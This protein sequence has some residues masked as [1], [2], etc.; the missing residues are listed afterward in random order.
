MALGPLPG[1]ALEL[2]ERLRH[3]GISP[4]LPDQ[5]IVNE[6]LPGQGIASHIDCEPCF[7]G[8]ICSLSLGSSCAMVM[9]QACDGRQEQI[10]LVPGSLLVSPTQPAMPGAT[11][12]RH[13]SKKAS[14]ARLSGVAGAFRSLSAPS[15][16]KKADLKRVLLQSGGFWRQMDQASVL[17]V[18]LGRIPS[19]FT[20]GATSPARPIPDW[21]KV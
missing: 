13:G 18:A 10:R 2:A 11:A 14:M 8:V 17:L 15:S 3:E 16:F 5:L 6:Y 7:G 9:T 20:T 1:W 21:R 4:A 19:D 12:S